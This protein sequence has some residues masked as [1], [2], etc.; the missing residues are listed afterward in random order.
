MAVDVATALHFLHTHHRVMH[1]D[2]KSGNVL[3]SA[4]WRACLSDLGVARALG[5]MSGEAGFSCTHAG[6][7]PA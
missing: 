4:D 1:A 7:L 3:L 6:G 5:S 2:L